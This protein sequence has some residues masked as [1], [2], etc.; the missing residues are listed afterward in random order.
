MAQTIK[1]KNGT[2][3]AAP[4]SLQQG[5]LAINVS[6]GSLWYGSG[7]AT[8]VTKSNFCF[9]E[10]TA[11]NQILN[12]YG[13]YTGTG[14]ITASGAITA[15][16]IF[17]ALPAGTDNSVVVLN[18]SNQLVTD[19][20][21]AA[22]WG[23][24][25]IITQG[26]LAEALVTATEESPAGNATTATTATVATN[27]TA[28]ATTDNADFFV[29]IMDGASGTQVVET[30]V[31]LKYNPG[32][33]SLTVGG[34]GSF[35]SIKTAGNITSSAGVVSRVGAHTG[36]FYNVTASNIIHAPSLSAS[37]EVACHNVN[38][39]NGDFDGTLEADAITI[40]G[41][42]LADTIAGT[43]VNNATLAGS[44]T[45]TDSTADAETP[46]VFHN[47]SNGLRDDT[48][49][50]TYNAA[51]GRLTVPKVNIT[52]ITASIISASTDVIGT[53]HLLPGFGKV[54]INDDPF[55]QNSVYFGHSTGNQPYNWN[56]P[57]AAGGT[58]GSTS[59]ITISED[60]TRW[61]HILPFDISKIEVQLSLRPGGACTG[62]NF[63]CGIYTASRPD[64]LAS[65]N[66][67]IALIAH[68]DATFAQGKYKTNDFTYTGNIDKGT[69]IFIGIGTEDSTAAKNAPGLLNVIVTKR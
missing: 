3:S 20:I 22:V 50:F 48:G 45:V 38:A 67:D 19:E 5:E 57:Q 55:V 14:A 63:F 35:G 56:D 31:H 49:T 15:G 68:N 62:D 40:G 21:Q 66:Y 53:E 34:S 27:V 44:V 59:T 1:I 26:I 65:A 23:S 47:E 30:A 12:Q 41:T 43:T 58:L 7:S 9:G 54:Y 36:S 51:N 42:S 10:I 16:S 8:H 24:D 52:N 29:G 69:L 17:S 64:G 37:G 39:V 25:A 28:V 33:K 61:G 46:V 6:S 2:S 13:N 18:S 11:S 32:T 4:A 60:D